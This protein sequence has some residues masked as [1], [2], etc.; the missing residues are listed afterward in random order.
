MTRGSWGDRRT[1]E[2]NNSP[3]GNAE[4]V[5]GEGNSEK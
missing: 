2:D 3:K 5:T 4:E 1:T